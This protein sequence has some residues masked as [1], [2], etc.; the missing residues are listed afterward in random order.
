MGKRPLD[1]EAQ[2]LVPVDGRG[3]KAEGR[4]EEDLGEVAPRTAAA[5]ALFAVAGCPRRTVRRRRVVAVV[6][7]VLD[8]L[9]HIAKHIVQAKRI[10]RE[11]ADRRGFLV[12]PGATTV[13]AVRHRFAVE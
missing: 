8:P 5:D 1:P 7:A 3:T 11:R 12:I 2:A 9:P 10:G 13:E 6:I 4:S